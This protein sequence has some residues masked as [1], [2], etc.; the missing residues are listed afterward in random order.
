MQKDDIETEITIKR[1]ETK[2][3]QNSLNQATSVSFDSPFCLLISDYSIRKIHIRR[4]LR[5]NV[6]SSGH[7]KT[8]ESVIVD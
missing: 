8:A 3:Q 6:R 2:L 4:T 5:T 1:P 7:I